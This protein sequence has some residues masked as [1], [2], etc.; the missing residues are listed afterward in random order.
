MNLARIVCSGFALCALALASSQAQ[1][2]DK[3]VVAMPTVIGAQYSDL[4][5]GQELGFFRDEGIELQLVAFQGSGVAIP[6]VVNKSTT[7]GLTESSLV[8]TALAKGE[9]LPV[10]FVYNYLRTNVNDFAVLADSPI[11]TLADLKGRKLGIGSLTFA[12]IPMTKAAFKDLGIVWQ[13]DVEIR[14]V[15]VGAAAWKQLETGQVDALNLYLSEDMR[16]QLSGL[17]IRQIAYPPNLRGIFASAFMAH[18]DT[19]RERPALVAAMGRAVAKSTLAC[20]AARQACARAFW[21]FDPT[22]R[23][24]PDKEAQWVQNT[25]LLLEAQYG[26]IGNFTTADRRWGSFAPGTLD[27]YMAALKDAGL[28]A[29]T[30]LPSEQI[31]SNQFIDEMNRFDS[32]AV[33]RRAREAEAGLRRAER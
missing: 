19:I 10:R 30:D 11:R 31:F 26:S 7:F 14:P 23:P 4:A 8:I 24:T 3:V 15:G 28:I 6:Q 2:L 18:A 1:A 29:R 22:S 20:A 25:V 12:S 27:G 9:P 32:E 21:K 17:K 5:F 16:M 13:K 33:V